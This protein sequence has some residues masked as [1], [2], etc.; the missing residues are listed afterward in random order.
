MSDAL[1]E[2]ISARATFK[3]RLDTYRFCDNVRATPSL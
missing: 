1:E 3:G 2:K